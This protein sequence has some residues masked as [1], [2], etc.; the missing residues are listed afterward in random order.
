VILIVFVMTL[1][2]SSL[3]ASSVIIAK[4][5]VSAIPPLTLTLVRAGCTAAIILVF[6]AITGR[7]QWPPPSTLALLAVGAVGSPFL[8]QI[9]LFY[10]LS[11]IDASKASLIGATQPVFV[12]LYSLIFFGSLPLLHQI[13]GGLISI[14]GVVMLIS[15]RN[16]R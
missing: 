7:L 13:L 1:F 4:H 2:S 14:G 12:L 3:Y 5:T 16:S 10:A 6:A 8:S 15:A 11:L 9:L